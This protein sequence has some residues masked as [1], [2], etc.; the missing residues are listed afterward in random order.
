MFVVIRRS[1]EVP[2]GWA[3]TLLETTSIFKLLAAAVPKFVV[4]E[5]NMSPTLKQCVFTTHL[6]FEVGLTSHV[7][8]LTSNDT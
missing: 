3:N 8:F 1:N 7:F 6:Y 4:S 2:K 5:I